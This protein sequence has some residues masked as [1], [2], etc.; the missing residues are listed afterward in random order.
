MANNAHPLMV[1]SAVYIRAY[2]EMRNLYMDT[3]TRWGNG[4]SYS[5]E[6]KFN[7]SMKIL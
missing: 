5:S 2:Y 6:N 3:Y 7:C 1:W 4:E